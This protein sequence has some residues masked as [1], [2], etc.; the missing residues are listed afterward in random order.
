MVALESMPQ[1]VEQSRLVQ[2]I[3]SSHVLHAILGKL[4]GQK[5]LLRGHKEL[6]VCMRA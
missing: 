2:V 1:V 4:I 3:E 6:D 5:Q